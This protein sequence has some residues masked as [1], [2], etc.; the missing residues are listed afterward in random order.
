M[1]S[2][3]FIRG[4]MSKNLGHEEFLQHVGNTI[5]KQ[6]QEWD[7]NYQVNIMK[8]ENYH[9]I[10]KNG[11]KDYWLEITE[12]ELIKLQNKSPF[13]LDFRLWTMLVVQGI[14]IKFGDGDYLLKVYGMFGKV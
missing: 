2:S 5:E 7:E 1:N 12:E 14:E 4:L 10:V 13:S 11:D 8:M 3:G 9:F 6:L